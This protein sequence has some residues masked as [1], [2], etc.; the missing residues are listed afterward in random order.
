MNDVIACMGGWCQ[1][2]ESC[3]HYRAVNRSEPAENL[4][5]DDGGN[6]W[7]RVGFQQKSATVEWPEIEQTGAECHR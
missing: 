3:G 2:R 7:M 6:Q 5:R 1:V 4:C